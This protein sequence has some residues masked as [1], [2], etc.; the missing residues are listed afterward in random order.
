[1]NFIESLE[2]R[3]ASKAMNGSSISDDARY[4]IL[5]AIR[6]TPT[7]L[8]L[9]AYEVIVV[10]DQAMKDKLAPAIYNQPQITKSDCVIIFAA[11]KKYEEK[12]VDSYIDLIAKTRK[13][14]IEE[15]ADFKKSIISSISGLSDEDFFNWSSKQTY[16]AL[17]FGLAACAVEG[18][19]STPMEGFSAK[20][21]DEILGLEAQNLSSTVILTVGNHDAS[22]DY[23]YGVKKVRKSMDDL[24]EII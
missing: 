10:R 7:S 2:K 16:I 13:Q 15:L 6:L 12:K 22:K 21:V 1:M 17:G 11:Q 5:E 19:D 14:P 24:I 23:L 4:R 3:Y 20:K 8:G 9:Q 18:V